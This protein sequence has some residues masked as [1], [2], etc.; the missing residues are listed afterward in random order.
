[1]REKYKIIILVSISIALGLLTGIYF[2]M[3]T[4]TALNVT[5][6]GLIRQEKN[7]KIH[8]KKVKKNYI[9][10]RSGY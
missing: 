7:K 8:I 4:A 1:M 6:L 9:E 3:L 10:G 5:G 2:G